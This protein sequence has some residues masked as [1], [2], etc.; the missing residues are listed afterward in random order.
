MRFAWHSRILDNFQRASIILLC[1]E[2]QE[3][4]N[5]LRI[6]NTSHIDELGSAVKKSIARDQY[7]LAKHIRIYLGLISPIVTRHTVKIFLQTTHV[8]RIA[9]A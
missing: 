6:G 5:F 8:T 9:T 4:F 1:L 7:L 3:H 2:M